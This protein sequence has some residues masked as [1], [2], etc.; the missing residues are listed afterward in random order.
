[1][2]NR[3]MRADP[4]DLER[5]EPPRAGGHHPDQR[6]VVV[7]VRDR[8]E[9]LLEVADLGRLEQAQP[10]DDGVRDVL[11][12]QP[13]HDRLAV[14]VL[15]VQ[16]RDVGPAAAGPVADLV[17]LIASTIATASSSGAGADD[18]L[19]RRS[20]SGRS[21]ARRLSGSK[22]VSLWPISRLAAV[23]T[24]PHGAEVLL[25]PEARRRAGR[26]RASGSWAGGRAKRRVELGEGGEAGAPEPVDRLVV[27]A[28]DHD[29]VGP[30]GRA[31]EQLDE[32]DLGDVRVLELVDEDVSEL[33]LPAAEDVRPA[34]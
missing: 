9:R 4:E 30:V 17:D 25:D 19:D 33:A 15:A 12:P 5:V 34:S 14:L 11:V 6:D 7:R 13:R 32:L 21:V 24:W 16:D 28:D 23:R 20:P 22:R 3:A 10:A 29:V 27:V 1:M 26:W 18:E 8:A 2:S 31:A